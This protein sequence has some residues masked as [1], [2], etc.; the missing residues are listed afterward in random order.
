MI[1][2]RNDLPLF[3]DFYI[4]AKENSFSLAAV[5]NNI[6]QPNLSRNVKTLESKLLMMAL[7]Y[8]IN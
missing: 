1:D 3:Y 5:K 8:I 4:V 7:V 6:S 2:L